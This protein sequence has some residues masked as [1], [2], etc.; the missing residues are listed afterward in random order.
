MKI[1]GVDIA[2]EIYNGM[3]SGLHPVTITSYTE[4][5]RTVGELTDGTNPTS[6]SYNS[7]GI[8]VN[9]KGK[10]FEGSEVETSDVFIG[11]L[12]KP[13]GSFSPGP[14]DIIVY[15]SVS[16]VVVSTRLDS[17]KAMYLCRCKTSTF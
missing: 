2:K 11:V 10:Y 6:V 12:G 17:A 13:L 7:R 3:A 16:H 14:G 1:F 4:G 8:A 5:T 9:Y 15:Q